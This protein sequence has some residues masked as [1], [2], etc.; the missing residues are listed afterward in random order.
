MIRIP[1][2]RTDGKLNDLRSFIIDLEAFQREVGH[3]RVRVQDCIGESSLVLEEL[4]A[5]TAKLSHKGFENLCYCIHQT[6]DGVFEGI[7]DDEV[8]VRLVAV[9]STYWEISAPTELEQEILAKY[10]E[11]SG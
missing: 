3:W 8:V 1:Q 11:Y 6:V 2:H 10:G 7:V 4:T 5:Q 9:D